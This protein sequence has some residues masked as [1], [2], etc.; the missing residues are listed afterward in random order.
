MIDSAKDMNPMTQETD[1]PAQRK[2][3]NELQVSANKS[4]QQSVAHIA[5]L[6]DIVIALSDAE[7]DSLECR[8]AQ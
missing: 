8:K 1:D 5:S 4:Q 2:I 6:G 3:I 7:D